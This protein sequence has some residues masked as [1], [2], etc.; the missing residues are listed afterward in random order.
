MGAKSAIIEQAPTGGTVTRETTKAEA[1]RASIEDSVVLRLAKVS[2]IIVEVFIVE[3]K[4]N[5][6]GIRLESIEVI[7][8]KHH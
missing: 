2:P 7:N 4:N 3:N 5:S 8:V 1:S 6:F